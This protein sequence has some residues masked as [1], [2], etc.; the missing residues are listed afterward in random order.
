[1]NDFDLE[2]KTEFLAE[3]LSNLSEVEAYFNKLDTSTDTKPLIEKMFFVAH[4]LKGGSLSVGFNDI[5]EFSNELELL[6]LKV[7]NGEIAFSPEIIKTILRSNN[8]LVEMLHTLQK[9][10]DETFDNKDFLVDLQN[11][12]LRVNKLA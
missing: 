6:V 7:K 4:N 1:M 8:R 12:Q 5:A 9:N 3:A 2:I 10:L 11:S